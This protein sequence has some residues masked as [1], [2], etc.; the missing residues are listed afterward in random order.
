MDVKKWL[1]KKTRWGEM[2]NGWGIINTGNIDIEYDHLDSVADLVIAPE[3]PFEGERFEAF[4]AIAAA[5]KTNGSLMIGQV[6]H[7]GRQVEKRINKHP[8]SASDIQLG[9]VIW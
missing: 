8:I 2:E 9:I 7:P 5:G 6:T 3:S 1:T 4:K